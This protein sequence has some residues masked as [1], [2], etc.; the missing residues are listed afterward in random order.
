MT[1]FEYS[2]ATDYSKINS[3]RSVEIVIKD[4][5][6]RISVVVFKLYTG[7]SMYDASG[8]WLYKTI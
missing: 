2:K 1:T 5:T 4:G 3:D 6:Y 8:S 7:S